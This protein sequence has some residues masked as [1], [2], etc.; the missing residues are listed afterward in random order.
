M[1]LNIEDYALISDCHTAALVGCDGSIDWL[2]LPRYDS[3]SMFGALLGTEDHGRWMLAPTD[4]NATCTRSYVD[5]TFILSTVW[6]TKDGSVEV[7]DFMPHGDKRADLVRRVRGITGTVHMQQ[8]LRMR[9]GYGSTI[10]WV[11][12]LRNED[13]HGLIAVAGPDAVVIRGPRL[14]AADH[15]HS[16]TF[17]VST[18]EIVDIEMTWY[19]SERSI[20]PAVDIDAVLK[21]TAEWWTGWAV[22]C[23]HQGPYHD[24]VV[25]S[26]LVLRALTHEDTGGIVAAATTS[27]PEEF[28]GSRNW[29]YRYVW[30]RDASLTL[31]VLLSHGYENEAEGWRA[32]LLRAIAGDPNDVQIMYGLSG[33]RDLPERELTSLPG[34][35]GAGPVRVGNGAVSQFQSDVIG[36]V[37]VAL[38]AA[39]IAGVGETEFSWPLQRSLMHFLEENWRRPDQGIWEVRGPAREFTHSRVMVWAAFDRAVRG[40]TEFGLDGPLEKWTALRDEVRRDIE[41]RGFSTARNS[42]TQSF[43]GTEVDASLLVL[44][45]VGFCEPTDARMLGT[46]AAIEA[47]LMRDGLLLRYRTAASVDGLSPGEHPFLAC[48]FWLVEQYAL[49]DRLDDATTLMNRL[50]G[51]VND[52]G[53]LSEEYDVT[54]GHQAGNTPQA[55]SHLALVRASGAIVAG[56]ASPLRALVH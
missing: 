47:D 55:L 9:F 31:E 40:I 51:F 6:T 50:V 25:R 56:T 29:D 14:H 32:W 41:L 45:Q 33:E 2:C 38:H 20:P 8:D 26:M 21:A 36:E 43:G 16:S 22:C 52:V 28:G 49:S 23:T 35:R 27:L 19:R 48:S 3:A 46:V 11:R 54:N 42:Y 1:A 24:A 7:L 10:P 17:T 4:A 12:Q 30:L 13:V 37:M 44:A 18:D 34:Y 39:R 15:R 5:E 53:L